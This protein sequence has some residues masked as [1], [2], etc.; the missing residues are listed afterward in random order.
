MQYPAQIPLAIQVIAQGLARISLQRQVFFGELLVL[1]MATLGS[2]ERHIL[3]QELRQS[4]Y[5]P[6]TDLITAGLTVQQIEDQMVKR[7]LYCQIRSYI[8]ISAG[9]N[10]EIIKELNIV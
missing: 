5:R 2:E 6:D 1:Y 4:S 9:S 7:A 3:Y 10:G 8:A